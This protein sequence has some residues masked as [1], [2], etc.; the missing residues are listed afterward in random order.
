M[1]T[2]VRLRIP[3]WASNRAVAT[4]NGVK[5]DAM[6]S[7]GSYLAIR[8]T[9]KT[10]DTLALEL[11]MGLRVESMPDDPTIQAVLY[12]PLVLAADMGSREADSKKVFGPMGPDMKGLPKAAPMVKKVG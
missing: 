1:E 3:G 12:G 10:G 8:R 5:L 6:A 11:P 7:P 9:W 4:L 2:T